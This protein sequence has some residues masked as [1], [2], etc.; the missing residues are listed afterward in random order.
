MKKL[1]LLAFLALFM[2]RAIAQPSSAAAPPTANASTVLSL[3]G[4]HYTQSSQATGTGVWFPNWG[5]ATSV[6]YSNIG[7]SDTTIRYS[8]LNYEGVALSGGNLDI[9]GYDSIHMDIWSSTCSVLN[10]HLIS[11]SP[12]AETGPNINLNNG[13]WTS[14][15][16]PLSTFTPTVALTR[17]FQMKFTGITPGSGSTIYL[18]NIYFKQAAGKPVITGFNVTSPLNTGATYTIVDPTSTSN[19]AFTYSSSNTS[20][21]TVAGN[22]ITCVGG[23]TTTIT[24]NQAAAGSFQA[25]SSTASL[26]VSFATPSGAAATPTRDPANVLSVFGKH[27]T[28]NAAAAGTAVWHQGWGDATSVTYTNIGGDTTMYS[29]NFNYQGVQFS[30]AINVSSYDSLHL[31]IWSPNCT[32]IYI[33][34]IGGAEKDLSY[35]LVKAGWNS[36]DIALNTYTPT[37]N[38]A[39]LLQFKFDITP[40]NGTTDI[41]SGGVVYYQNIYFYKKAGGPTITGFTIPNQTYTGTNGTYTITNPT[42]NSSGAFTYTS[43]NT[44]VATISGNVITIL[45][46]GTANITANQAAAGAFSA[47]SVSATLTVDYASPSTAAPTPTVAAPYVVSLFGD[48]YTNISGI[49][50]FPNWGQQTTVTYPTIG[51]ASTIKYSNLNYE[52][53]NMP[54]DENVST[55]DSLR[56]NVWSPNC[57]SLKVALI[58]TTGGTVQQFVTFSLTANTW[59]TISIPLTSFSPVDLSKVA[60]MSFTAVTPGSGAIIYLQNIYFMNV[61]GKPTITGF[62]IPNQVIG[63]GTYTI[64]NPTSNST[65]AFTYTSS[66]TSVATISGNTI[67]ILA[68]GTSTITANQAADSSYLSGTAT[69]VL[70]VDYAG[71]TTAA[72]TPARSSNDVISLYGDTYTNVGG[73]TWNPY[74]GQPTP[75]VTTYPTIGGASTIKYASLSYEGVQFASN[76]DASAMDSLH[77]DVWTPNCTNFDI[78]LINTGNGANQL[79]TVRPTTGGWNSINI[80]MSSFAN[81]ANSVGQFKFVANTPASG[82]TLYLQNIYFF[83][84]AGKPTISGFTLPSNLT[85]TS[86]PFK[87][88]APTSNSAGAFTYSS[89]NTAIATISNDTVTIKGAG[90]AI[91]TATQAADVVNGFVSGTITAALSVAFPGPTTAAAVPTATSGNVISLWGDTY[92]NVSGTTWNPYWGQPAPGVTT[93]TISVGGKTTLKYVNLGYQGVQFATSINAS[94]MKVLHFDLWSPNCTNLEVYM[95]NGTSGE[96]H[97]VTVTPTING[98]NSINIPLSNYSGTIV[99]HVDQFKFVSNTP[100]SNAVLY[101]QNIYFVNATPTW[102]GATSNDYSLAANWDYYGLVPISTDVITIPS[103]AS[104]QPMLSANTTIAGITL[105]GSLSLNGK[106]LTINGPVTGSGSLKGSAT[107]NLI[108]NSAS[109]GTFKFGTSSTDSLLNSLLLN[110]A[111][112]FTLG[113]GL[114]ITSLLS[115]NNAATVVDLNNNHLTLKSTSLANTAEVGP[116]T[117]GASIINGNVTVERFIPQELRNYRDLGASVANAG[118]VFANWQESGAAG[119]N[120]DKGFFITG[121]AAKYSPYIPGKIFEP[122]S[123]LDYTTTGAP[124]LYTYNGTTWPAVTSTKALSLNPFQGYRAIVRGARNFNMGTN[125]NTMPTAATVRASGSLVIGDVTM[126]TSGTTN[127]I[128]SSSFG[129]STGSQAYS[130][131]ANPYACPVQWSKILAHSSIYNTYWYLDPTY[132][133]VSGNQRYITVQYSGGSIIVTPN[134]KFSSGHNA[135]PSFDYIQSGQGIMVNNYGNATP[136]ISFREA[137]KATGQTHNDVFG[138]TT[139]SLLSIELYKNNSLT[140]AAVANFNNNFTKAIGT[141]DASKMMNSAEN[142]SITE[143]SSDLSIDGLPTPS[144]NDVLPVRLGQIVAN[145]TYQLNVDISNF[146]ASGLQAYVRDNMLNTEVAAGNM[147]SFTPTSVDAQSYKDRFSVVFKQSKVVPVINVKGSINV[148]PN[149]VTAKSFKVQTSNIAAGKYTVV[150][151]NSFGQEVSSTPITHVEGSN[152]ETITMSKRLSTGVYTLVLKSAEGKTIYQTELLAK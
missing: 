103:A 141:E 104:N 17:F 130:L 16:L 108:V 68:V 98:W 27:Y 150:M 123:G 75:V 69:S 101:F 152:N 22:V 32:K 12:T 25:G 42:S 58:K 145:T 40:N 82:V 121:T 100:S 112:R 115:L 138:Q 119:A 66:N 43:G 5:Q 122:I 93:S 53:V 52:G 9:S 78:Y 6:A 39:S 146:T 38:L 59:N 148:F 97:L 134:P 125:P 1:F 96:N 126:T 54:A 44:S 60:Q 67:N 37:V 33:D 135:D 133:D 13:S 132:Q 107:S 23:G 57:T 120:V 124:S 131:I 18:E 70:T 85:T 91:I 95:I 114:G 34:M 11:A 99:N 118:S 10:F 139:N 142:I 81:E 50:W 48:T 90:S 47:G 80:P 3:F 106:T 109:A 21:A 30:P 65:G 94:T 63:V 24:C 89:S 129:L 51:G 113:S 19:G 92:T 20:V 71:P 7:G 143:S 83:K 86:A 36:I 73:T 74:W 28:Q 111:G 105:N 35:T 15:T 29:T 14:V 149:P 147:I 140:D 49:N 56:F 116:I 136:S 88:T 84:T 110:G 127:N 137:D 4:S 45:G 62:S 87:I 46:A 2:I 26:T 64:T 31:D 55:M 102:T 79:V 76:I 128:F 151:V 41:K 8:N 144:V 61:V 72:P 77:F 117:S